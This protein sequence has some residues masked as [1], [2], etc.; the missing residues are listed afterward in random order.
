MGL[1]WIYREG[2]IE[3]SQTHSTSTL[4]CITS[5]E[6]MHDKSWGRIVVD[7]LVVRWESVT[8]QPSLF[9][10]CCIIYIFT[11]QWSTCFCSLLFHLNVSVCCST[12]DIYP[13]VSMTATDLTWEGL[14]TTHVMWYEWHVSWAKNDVTNKQRRPPTTNQH[15][16]WTYDERKTMAVFVCLF[17]FFRFCRCERELCVQGRTSLKCVKPVN[18]LY[19]L[20]LEVAI[21]WCVMQ[22]SIPHLS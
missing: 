12:S 13:D 20:C 19:V 9:F 14:C 15:F 10:C 2:Y 7:S 1:Y 11:Q 21:R 8:K 3:Y 18:G 17:F 16:C 4:L 22:L 6:F 5:K